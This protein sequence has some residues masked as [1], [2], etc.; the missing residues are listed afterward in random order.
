MEYVFGF[1][2][3]IFFKI[4]ISE[5]SFHLPKLHNSSYFFN[6]PDSCSMSPTN[7]HFVT[8]PNL[9]LLYH[10]PFFG[11]LHI[12]F[13]S[14]LS[15]NSTTSQIQV[16]DAVQRF[17]ENTTAHG[18]P[19]ILRARNAS[20]S[21]FWMIVWLC[22]FTLLLWE[23]RRVITNLPDKSSFCL[24]PREWGSVKQEGN[25]IFQAKQLLKKYNQNHPSTSVKVS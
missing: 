3:F 25:V 13:F 5:V 12:M 24:H 17:L 10:L 16:K 19:R 4:L 18:L 14:P 22:F 20:G 23:V 6:D 2:S 7:Q 9:F 1:F 8:F 21:G 15:F 11:L